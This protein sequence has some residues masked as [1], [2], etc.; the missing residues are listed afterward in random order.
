MSKRRRPTEWTAEEDAI[1]LKYQD[2]I[3]VAVRQLPNRTEGAI[4]TRKLRLFATPPE[5]PLRPIPPAGPQGPSGDPA[6]PIPPSGDQG[7]LTDP[8]ATKKEQEEENAKIRDQIKKLQEQNALILA[9]IL[10]QQPQ[11]KKEKKETAPTAK[12]RKLAETLQSQINNWKTSYGLVDI[13]RDLSR[14]S[15]FEQD[16]QSFCQGHELPANTLP[17]RYCQLLLNIVPPAPPRQPVARPPG[18]I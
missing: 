7:G 5:V 10:Q 9:K 11:E 17:S 1:V 3:A 6:G 15:A 8:I 14:L 2:N 12:W 18:L 16:W 4:K 13:D